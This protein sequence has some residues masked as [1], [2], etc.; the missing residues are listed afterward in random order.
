ME[1]EFTLDDSPT[2]LNLGVQS[3]K[4]KFHNQTDHINE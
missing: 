2:S 1:Q 3:Y 4:I